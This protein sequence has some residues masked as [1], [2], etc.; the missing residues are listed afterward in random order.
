MFQEPRRTSRKLVLVA[1]LG[2]CACGQMLFAE[3]PVPSANT[4]IRPAPPESC[5][6]LDD[7]VARQSMD[8]LLF[9]LLWSCGRQSELGNQ[10]APTG[11]EESF[12]D[13]ARILQIP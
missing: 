4:V 6:L 8:G 13:V 5:R 1:I 11:E 2:M 10:P 12:E 7:P 9:N 3:P